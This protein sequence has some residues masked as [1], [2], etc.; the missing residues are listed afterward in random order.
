MKQIIFNILI[1]FSFIFTQVS[2]ESIPKSFLSDMNFNLQEIVLPEVDVDQLI[3]ED[4][5]E[6]ESNEMK[7]YRFAKTIYVDLNMNNSGTWTVLED[8]SSIWRLKIKSNG[9]YSL[10]LIYDVFNIPPNAEFFLYSDEDDMML[11]AFTDFNH[12]PHGGFSTA[13]LK[14]ESIILEYNEPANAIFNGEISINSVGHDYKNIF[15]KNSSRGYGDSGSCNNNA[16]CPVGDDWEDEIRSVAMILTS[17]GSRLCTGSL[18]NNTEQDLRPLFLTANHC[19][20]GN[21]SWIFMFNYESPGCTNQDGPTNMTVSGSTLL[22]NSG[23][24]D[25]A[26]LELNEEPP[27]SY[28]VHFSGWDVTGNTPNTPVC[29]HHPSGDIKK[30]TFDY[31]NASNSGNYWDVNQWEDGTTEPG[32]SGSPLFDGVSHRIVGQLYGG[33]ASCTSITYDTYGKTSSSWGLGLSQ[34]LDPQNTGLQILD[35]T[36]TG[37]GITIL[38]DNL[39]DM[40]YENNFINI[41]ANVASNTGFIENVLLYYDIGEGFVN[42]EMNLGFGN[43]YQAEI[44]GLYNGMI[45]EYYFQAINS[46]GEL[47][48]YPNNAPENT[49]LFILGDLPDLYSN[50]FEANVDG[51]IIGDFNDDA[52]AGIWELAEPVATYD[53]DNNQIQPGEDYSDDGTFCFITGNGFESGNGGFDDVDGGKTTLFSPEFN[54][55]G[56]DEVI[57]T[58]WRWYTNNVGDNGNNDKWIVS[59]TNNGNIW[60]N[61]E[62]TTSSNVDWS[63]QR[64]ILSDYIDLESTIQFKFVAEDIFYSGDDGSGG[65]LVEAA[66]DNFSL[67]YIAENSNILGDVN[68]DTNVDVLDVVLVVN[69]ILGTEN[70][71]YAAD[72]NNDNA[73]N[74]QDIIFLINLI[75]NI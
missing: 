4:I 2:I 53:D 10:N 64:F 44:N 17:G 11:G 25:F 66:I 21:N 9:A 74:V 71:N 46:E 33:T 12:K 19:L 72:L 23:N 14:G 60:V 15:S 30:I 22:A 65:S 42:Q 61:L 59:V 7:P 24:S 62:N 1:L 48:M 38:H 26:L 75:I 8:G 31:D 34:H 68:N 50:N 43:N 54:T 47:Q 20:G 55:S 27:D 13:P 18:I 41:T 28:N 40:P 3:E 16:N 39:D 58:Y 36:S 57:V 51:W 29:I 69:M 6:M 49:I 63:K 5:I 35:G 73:V 56:L 45:I 67:E 52:S 37:G 32:S 70:V